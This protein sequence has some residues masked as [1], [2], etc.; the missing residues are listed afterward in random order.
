MAGQL[1]NQLWATIGDLE[2]AYRQALRF[3]VQTNPHGSEATSAAWRTVAQRRALLE[4]TLSA[5][6][7]FLGPRP[8]PVQRP[9]RPRT[10]SK[11]QPA[12]PPGASAPS[13]KS[14]STTGTGARPVKPAQ[15]SSA[16]ASKPSELAPLSPRCDDLRTN[17][18]LPAPD[19]SF[20]L[21]QSAPR[22]RAT[23][24]TAR[25]PGIRRHTLETPRFRIIAPLAPALRADHLGP[26]HACGIPAQPLLPAPT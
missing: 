2:R 19:S 22:P 8:V 21:P 13:F 7:P 17:N 16:P 6:A 18:A 1:S 25:R 9:S 4:K 24:G 3:A 23:S 11:R 20:S 14:T 5:A 10:A 15:A 26:V 12:R